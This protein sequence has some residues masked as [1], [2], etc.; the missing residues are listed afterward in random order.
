M[1]DYGHLP[2]E[3]LDESLPIH[4]AEASKL[5]KGEPGREWRRVLEKPIFSEVIEEWDLIAM[6][7]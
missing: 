1:M 2:R 4:Q 5:L 7:I 6:L 3:T